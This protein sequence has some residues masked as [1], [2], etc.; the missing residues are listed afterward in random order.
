MDK[1]SSDTLFHSAVS[2]MRLR[3]ITSYKEHITFALV[4]DVYIAYTFCNL[5]SKSILGNCV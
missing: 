4:P 5:H 3:L 1:V 2:V